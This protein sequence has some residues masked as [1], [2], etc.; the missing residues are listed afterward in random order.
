M[1]P[2]LLAHAI[3]SALMTIALRLLLSYAVFFLTSCASMKPSDFTGGRP[4]FD[5]IA[6]FS[7]HTSSNGVLETRR[8]TPMQLVT[9]KTVGRRQRDVLHLEQDLRLGDGKRQHR[10]WRIWRVG[11]HRYEAAAN[12]IIGVVHGEAYGNVFHWSFTLAIS[13]GNPLMNVR[14]SQWM[15]L[16]P[17]GRTM[18]NHSTIRKAGF[19]I[20]QVTEQFR[21][22]ADDN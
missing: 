19:V 15:Y 13:P 6:F 5:P 2:I 16:Q 17:D 22:R 1:R 4:V 10:S 20:A 12:D 7:G 21:R 8:G 9:T 3:F 11:T 18:I 14:M